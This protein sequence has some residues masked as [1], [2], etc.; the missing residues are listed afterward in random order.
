M[1]WL[2]VFFAVDLVLGILIAIAL[3]RSIKGWSLDRKAEIEKLLSKAKPIDRVF[4]QA[5]VSRLPPPVQRYLLK[6]IIQGTPYVSRLHLKQSGRMRF[7]QR[8]IS[9][10]ADQYYSAEPLSFTWIAKM[11]L[12]PAWVAARD[13]YSNG[14]G[15]MLIKILSAVPL[16]DVRGPE[17]DHASLLRYLSELPWLPTAFLSDHITWQAIDDRTAEATI[18]D[19][20]ISAT[21]TFHFNGADEISEFKS[22][23]RFRSETGKITPWSGTWSNYQEFN[24]FRIPTEGNAV[25]NDPQGDFEYVRLKI[26]TAEYDRR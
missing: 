11:K 26:E 20:G 3:G 5:D 2:L 17:M 23:G 8:W 15:N 24:G 16:F 19:G 12:G 13:R 22:L 7:N 9:I 1:E 6:A 25:W 4:N 21:A 18:T 14:K 10:E